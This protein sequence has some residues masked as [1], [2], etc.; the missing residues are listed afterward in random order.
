MLAMHARILYL[1]R[2]L[3]SST[4]G[5]VAGMYCRVWGR[6][7]SRSWQDYYNSAAGDGMSARMLSAALEPLSGEDTQ[8]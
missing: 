3:V 5:R 8:P 6:K 2:E 7:D 4:S 1:D